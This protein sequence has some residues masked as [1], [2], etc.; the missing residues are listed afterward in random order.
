VPND[1]K[2]HAAP[3]P[4]LG[5][6]AM[7]IGAFVPLL[8]WNHGSVFAQAYLA[9]AAVLVV[10]G[11][12]DDLWELGPRAKMAGQVVAA[13]VAV[14][15]GGVEIRSLGGLLPDGVILP[16]WLSVP[17]TL[18]AIVGV[19][20]AINLS[21]GLDGLA[22]GICLLVFCCIGYLAYLTGNE[23]VGLA[24]V[25]LSGCIFGFLRFNTHPA[26]IFMG[27]SGSQF[28]GFSAVT[29][30][31]ALTQGDTPISPLLPLIILGFPILDTLTVMLTRI[32]QGRSPFVA[33]KNHFHHH[34][35]DLGLQHAEA[36]LVV[37]ILQT[38]LVVSA[39]AFRFYTDW[40]LLAGYLVF[41]TAVLAAFAAAR[42]T[43][44][45]LARYDL[46]DVVIR[47]NLRRLRDEGI[48]I[49]VTF[50][51]FEIAI[52]LLL[53]LS[54]LLP[55]TVPDYFLY[56]SLGA[57]LLLLA[58]RIFR[59]EAL[60]TALRFVLYLLIPFAVY[61]GDT[62]PLPWVNPSLRGAYNA[63][64]GL[65]AVSIVV[66]SKFTRRRMGFKNTP[67][68]FLILFLAVAVPN[69]P[70]QHIQDYR[71]GLIAAKII[72]LYFS[73]EVLM[74][75]ARGNYGKIAVTTVASLAVLGFK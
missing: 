1:R 46:L 41:S 21:D 73:F 29:F 26:T 20:N 4:R 67:M 34:L 54:C 36:V 40:L 70:E 37:Y 69:F 66:I 62:H 61:L 6:V 44:W 64:F 48:I 22:G 58:V 43:G 68:D 28:L 74:A 2:V 13:L 16:A 39:F 59:K 32:A 55:A 10:T 27:D 33:D 23:I 15:W 50:R 57:I 7:A 52:P 14:F 65:F 12:A 18:L 24:A 8:V 11:V 3:I 9:G 71:L 49:K 19:T 38:V 53:L 72:M 60:G 31:L 25:A 56:V 17:L 63:A 45:R 75:E 30:S 51:V 35:L 47:G 42:R 5:G